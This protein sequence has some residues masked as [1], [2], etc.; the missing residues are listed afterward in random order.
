MRFMV[1]DTLIERILGLDMELGNKD[2]VKAALQSIG[3]D[4]STMDEVYV[5]LQNRINREAFSRIPFNERALF[6]SHCLKNSEKCKAG[7]TDNGLIC[8]ECGCCDIFGLKREAEK[9]GYNFYVVPGGS[10]VFN[11]LK[12]TKPKTCMGVACYYELE[13]AFEKLTR[14]NMP[15]QGVP[16]LRD[17]CKDTEAEISQ[18]LKIMRLIDS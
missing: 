12:R 6:L 8:E 2:A 13:E 9:L 17:G 1:M 14:I 4:I 18:V 15:Y 5:E 7:L 16:L 11:I 3:E 10:M